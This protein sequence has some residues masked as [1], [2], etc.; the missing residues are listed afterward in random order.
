MMR[1]KVSS[2]IGLAVMVAL[3]SILASAQGE[4]DPR[5]K[6]SDTN[7]AVIEG[8]VALPSGFLAERPIRITLRNRQM[9]LLTRFTD[10]HGGFRFDNLPEGY[11]TVQADVSD[12]EFER[13]EKQ[14]G[15]GRGIVA[16]VTLQLVEKKLSIRFAA[17]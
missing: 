10:K 15:L 6:T 12:D 5:Y 11:Y 16:Q 17:S 7:N 3:T 9:V 14:I 4:V 1:V 2:S 13:A 8:R